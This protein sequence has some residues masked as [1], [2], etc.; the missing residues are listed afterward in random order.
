MGSR[1]MALGLAAAA[2]C[3]ALSTGCG[4]KQSDEQTSAAA[5]RAEA[6]AAR[7]EAAAKRTEAAASRVEAAAARAEAALDKKMMK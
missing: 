3:A 1:S 7:A 5:Q 2:L 4:H 6:A